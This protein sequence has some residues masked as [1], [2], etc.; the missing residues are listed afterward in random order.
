[1]VEPSSVDRELKLLLCGIRVVLVALV[2]LVVLGFAL[3][4]LRT[5]QSHGAGQCTPIAS[6]TIC[7]VRS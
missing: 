2:L 7:S 4:S 3:W 5:P 6:G 1:M